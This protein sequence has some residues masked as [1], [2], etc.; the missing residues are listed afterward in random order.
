MVLTAVQLVVFHT[1]D[2]REVLVNP[3]HVTSVYAAKNGE[4]NK[5]YTEKARCI[6]G[7]NDGK[8]ITVVEDCDIVK[9]DL[10]AAK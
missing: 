2:D 10:E 1:I 3:F 8:F 6:I 4:H 7:T 9:R 5:L